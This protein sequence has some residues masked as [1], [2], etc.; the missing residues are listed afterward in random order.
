MIGPVAKTRSTRL[1][2]YLKSLGISSTMRRVA[3]L[4]QNEFEYHTGRT[5]LSSFPPQVTIDIT[6]QCNLRCPLCLTGRKELNRPSSTMTIE[7]YSQLIGQIAERSFQVFLYCWGEP[8]LVKNIFEYVKIAKAAGLAVTLSSNLSLGLSD[9]VIE[10]LVLAG[11]DRLIVSLDGTE[12]E[13]YAKYRVGGSLERVLENVRRFAQAKAHH[14]K[15][16]PK[17]I[18]QFLV[19]S[20]NESQIETAQNAYQGW[21]FDGFEVEKPNLPFGC[22]DEKLARQWFAQNP[23]LRL[24]DKWDIKDNVGAFCFWPWRS[25]VIHPDGGLAREVGHAFRDVARL[26]GAGSRLQTE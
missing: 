11:A 4:V 3:N 25:A 23:E 1:A 6:N 8:L 21:G 20:H 24:A 9:N 17:L 14:E 18:W 26:V 16:T 19:F 13:T 15:S 12:A 2:W 22:N 10:S 7:D 5:K